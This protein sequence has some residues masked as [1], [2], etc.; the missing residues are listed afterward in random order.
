MMVLMLLGGIA[1]SQIDTSNV[2]YN[3]WGIHLKKAVLTGGF[4]Q[5][6][7]LK[8]TIRN[9]TSS[10]VFSVKSGVLSLDGRLSGGFEGWYLINQSGLKV[11]GFVLCE[12]LL[13]S[14]SIDVEV[15]RGNE[16]I[17]SNSVENLQKI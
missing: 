14:V 5:G 15:Y 10:E 13:F 1:K 6:D 17:Y 7:S 11:K 4:Q 12:G 8:L 16:V 3:E 2:K 9:Y